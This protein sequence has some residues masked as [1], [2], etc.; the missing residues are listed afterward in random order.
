MA[1]SAEMAWAAG[2]FEGEG[3]FRMTHPH[4]AKEPVAV[5]VLQMTDEDTVSRFCEIVGSGRVRGPEDRGP[6]HKPMFLLDVAARADVRRIILAF[7]PWLG[8]RRTAKAKQL[9]EHIERLDAAAKH[10]SE[11]CPRGHPRTPETTYVNP[12]GYSYC[13]VCKRDIGREWMQ[14]KRASSP[15]VRE[16]ERV[17]ARAYQRRKRAGALLKT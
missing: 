15:E 4:H 2:I 3:C 8:R 16:R 5:L 11:F 7:L 10:R 1:T 13:R 9:L 12:R 6:G 17:R 14:Q